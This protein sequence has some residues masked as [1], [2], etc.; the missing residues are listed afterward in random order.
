MHAVEQLRQLFQH[1]AWADETLR[2]AIEKDAGNAEAW[3]EYSHILGAS[4]VWLDRMLRRPQRVAVWPTLTRPEAEELRASL[5]V[6]YPE[7]L[8]RLTDSELE[9]RVDYVNSAGAAFSTPIGEILLH[10]AMHAQYH[11]GKVNL[12]L[13][14]RGAEPAPTDFIS[15]VRGVPAAT[16][17]DGMKA[18]TAEPQRR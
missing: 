10:V 5:A 6:E 9:H 16:Q 18:R 2:S 17:A 13:R 8:G 3:R 11:R 4:A 7:L 12:L 14:Q 1:S 15:F